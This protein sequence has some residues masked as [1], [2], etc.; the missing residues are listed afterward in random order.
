MPPTLCRVFSVWLSWEYRPHPNPAVDK[1][2]LLIG[3]NGDFFSFNVHGKCFGS[4]AQPLGCTFS[5]LR[6][7]I[8]KPL[9]PGMKLQ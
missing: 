3:K 9:A 6:Q 5:S 4:S 7:Q 1:I 2:L 8:P